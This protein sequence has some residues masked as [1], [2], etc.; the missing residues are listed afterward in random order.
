MILKVLGLR[1]DKIKLIIADDHKIIRDGLKALVEKD[2]DIEVV[3]ET[4]N[5]RSLIDLLQNHNPQVIIMDISMPEMNGIEATRLIKSEFPEIKII[6]LSMHSDRRYVSEMLKSGANGYMLKDCAY[7]EMKTA[8]RHVMQDKTYL[9]SGV[10]GMVIDDYISRLHDEIDSPLKVLTDREKEVMQ[11]I[12]EGY[13]TKEIA[14]KINLS[15]KTIETHR[16]N[17]MDKLGVYSIAALTKM[18][19]K[20]GLIKLDY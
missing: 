5:G 3:A 13:S 2:E 17:T 9:S 7:N 10:A 18:A 19:I 14:G 16:K 1:M 11:F 20:E 8:I 4:C 12:A 15:V 6:A